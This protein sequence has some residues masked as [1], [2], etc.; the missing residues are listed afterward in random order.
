VL[1]CLGTGNSRNSHVLI[2]GSIRHGNIV[3]IVVQRMNVQSMI[4]GPSSQ[5]AQ[6]VCDLLL[7]GDGQV[8]LG[9]A[10]EDD[11]ALA[12]GDGQVANLVFGVGRVKNLL[13]FGRWVFAADDGSDI[14]VFEVVDCPGVFERG[15]FQSQ[16]GYRAHL[17][18]QLKGVPVRLYVCWLVWYIE[19][20]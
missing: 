5:L 11:T 2:S 15:A 6:Q 9:S 18:Q 3:G 13:Q 12:D 7:L 8:V 19:G 14:D 10:E 16:G 17:V 20:C 1:A 4:L